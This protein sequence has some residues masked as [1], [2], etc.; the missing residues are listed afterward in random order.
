MTRQYMVRE[1]QRGIGAA[2][3][4]HDKKGLASLIRLCEIYENSENSNRPFERGF[5]DQANIYITEHLN[6]A[7]EIHIMSKEW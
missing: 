5:I 1:Y 7:D 6:T 4:I 3:L 2:I